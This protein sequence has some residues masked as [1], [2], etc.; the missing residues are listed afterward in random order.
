MPKVKNAAASTFPMPTA[1]TTPT[2]SPLSDNRLLRRP[3]VEELVGLKTSALYA[4]MKAGLF[5]RPVKIGK[6]GVAWRSADIA[7]F[8][9]NGAAAE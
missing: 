4:N 1:S 8:L 5:P 7:A 2:S 9:Q 3:E 6:R